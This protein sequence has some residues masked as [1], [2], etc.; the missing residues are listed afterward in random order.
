M[1]GIDQAELRKGKP[2]VRRIPGGRT[3]SVQDIHAPEKVVWNTIMDVKRYPKM[4]DGCVA[5]EI[6]EDRRTPTG[7]RLVKAKYKLRIAPGA[8]LQ[9]SVTHAF[10][11]LKHCM[12]FGLDY[13]QKNQLKDMCG[14]WYVEQLAKE[15]GDDVWSRVYFSSDSAIP[16]FLLWAKGALIKQAAYKNLYWVEKYSHAAMGI[17]T[18]KRGSSLVRNA[19]VGGAV[20]GGAMWWRGRLAA[21]G[22]GAS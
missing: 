19:I 4:I 13:K 14:Y 20:V 2:V 12:I 6:Y 18:S 11:P 21:A 10:E 5:T 15:A 8:G 7:G 1:K 17:G 9:Y 16:S 22:E 3:M